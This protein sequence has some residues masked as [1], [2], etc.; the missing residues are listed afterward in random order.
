MRST[1]KKGTNTRFAPTV[2]VIE[3]FVLGIGGWGLYREQKCRG[4]PCDCPDVDETIRELSVRGEAGAL[5]CVRD[6]SGYETLN[7]L[8]ITNYELRKGKSRETRLT[9]CMRRV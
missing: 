5:G 7:K 1:N 3:W 8:R 4:N 9:I 2:C 6:R